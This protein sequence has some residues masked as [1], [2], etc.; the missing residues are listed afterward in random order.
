MDAVIQLRMAVGGGGGGFA[1]PT[2]CC[3]RESLA[4]IRSHVP[5]EH[6]CVRVLLCRMRRETT[7]KATTGSIYTTTRSHITHI[8][9]AREPNC[10]LCKK[11]PSETAAAAVSL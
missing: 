1:R 3:A 5:D 4:R 2:S 8:V 10:T 11:F 6:I 9:R 7:S